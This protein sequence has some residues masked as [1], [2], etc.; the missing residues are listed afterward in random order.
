[1]TKILPREAWIAFTPPTRRNQ[2]H[3]T[4]GQIVVD[5]AERVKLHFQADPSRRMQDAR[6]LVADE[7]ENAELEVYRQLLRFVILDGF[8]FKAVYNAFSSIASFAEAIPDG[9]WRDP[10]LLHVG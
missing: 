1:M 5:T 4:C 6:K 7:V 2:E 10:Q 3:Y 8:H 9:R